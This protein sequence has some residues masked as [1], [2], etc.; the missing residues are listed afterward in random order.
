MRSW[1][2]RSSSSMRAPMGAIRSSA[3][4][5]TVSANSSCSG[6]RTGIGIPPTDQSFSRT[7]TVLGRGRQRVR[8]TV[9]RRLVL[10]LLAGEQAVD[11]R[12]Q[13]GEA[14]LE[15]NELGLRR[16]VVV[17]VIVGVSVAARTGRRALLSAAWFAGVATAVGEGDELLGAV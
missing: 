1:G 15:L 14:G 7:L 8:R 16:T 17:M 13:L 2:K 6:L 9:L 5:L 10:G 12:R 11:R 4:R 3:T